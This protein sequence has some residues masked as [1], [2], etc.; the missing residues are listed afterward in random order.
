MRILLGAIAG[1]VV[2]FLCVIGVEYAA[3]MVYPPPPGFDIAS[4]I[5]AAQQG[6]QRDLLDLS[7]EGRRGKRPRSPR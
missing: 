3:H 5:R 1:T 7:Q 6:V 2:A 4:E